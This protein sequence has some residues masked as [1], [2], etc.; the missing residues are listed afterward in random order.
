MTG[1]GTTLALRS[2]IRRCLA[3]GMADPPPSMTGTLGRDHRMGTASWCPACGR[4]TAACAARL[5][6]AARAGQVR[7]AL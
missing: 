5:C 7:G 2:A 1:P 3:C 6:S 4:L